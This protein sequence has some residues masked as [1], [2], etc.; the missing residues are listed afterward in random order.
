GSLT[1]LDILAWLSTRPRLFLQVDITTHITFLMF[2]CAQD[3]VHPNRSITMGL[4]LLTQAVHA[5]AKALVL[6]VAIRA[7]LAPF[8]RG[9]VATAFR[10]RHGSP[11]EYGAGWQPHRTDRKEQDTAHSL[12][13]PGMLQLLH[14]AGQE[15]KADRRRSQSAAPQPHLPTSKRLS[16]RHRYRD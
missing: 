3:T 6:D 2:L 1:P 13:L 10:S 14:I 15:G 11:R 16:D 12:H 9:K 7:R 4:A 5:G 8:A